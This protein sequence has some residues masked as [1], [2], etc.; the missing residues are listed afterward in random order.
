M[1]LGEMSSPLMLLG[2]MNSPLMLLGEMNSPLHADFAMYVAKRA[3]SDR[4]FTM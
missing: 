4:Y 3:R 2:E 1:L